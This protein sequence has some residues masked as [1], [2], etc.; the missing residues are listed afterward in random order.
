MEKNEFFKIDVEANYNHNEVFDIKVELDS[1]M[2][3][4]NN[5]KDLLDLDTT[6]Y[7][8]K[9][10]DKLYFLPGVNVPRVKLKDLTLQWGVKVVRDIKDATIVFGGSNTIY[11]M[12]TNTHLY[13][14]PVSLV[15]SFLELSKSKM[16]IRYATNLETLLEHY[17]KEFFYGDY[18]TRRTLLDEGFPFFKHAI[19]NPVFEAI[20]N[21]GDTVK[22]SRWTTIIDEQEDVAILKKIKGINVK[23]ENTL[24]SILNSDD[25]VTI[26]EEVFTNLTQMLRSSDEDNHVLAMEIMANCNYKESLMYLEILF[27]E[28]HY[29]M[30][31]V[32]AKNH[33]NFKSLLSYL[34]KTPSNMNTYLDD[35]VE[36]LLEKGV[37]DQQKLDYIVDR[38]CEDI[39]RMGN[40]DVFK[41]KTVTVNES[42]L[43]FINKNY[44]FDLLEEFEPAPEPEPEIIENEEIVEQEPQQETAPATEEDFI[45]D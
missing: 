7:V 25:C 18:N 28:N 21:Y 44:E 23:H 30:S 26:D 38:Y 14:F 36:S 29:T 6:E 41:V 11:K 12:C 4:E 5:G 3:S 45:W 27:H 20:K 19:V 15:K 42:I 8:V 10:G 9:P 13:K 24:L 1:I 33:V 40:S 37:V 32:H 16:D 43:Q 39:A 31:R 17:D 2:V 22:H 34:G 35:I